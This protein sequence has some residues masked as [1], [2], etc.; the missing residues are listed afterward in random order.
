[1]QG[2]VSIDQKTGKWAADPKNP[3]YYLI[4]ER[5]VA[6]PLYR[7]RSAA[8]RFGVFLPTA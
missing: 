8:Y 5:Q 3:L 4:R 1:L 7:V 6:L 2:L